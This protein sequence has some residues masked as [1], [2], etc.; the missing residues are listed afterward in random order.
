MNYEISTEHD[1]M[2]L[3]VI[4]AFLRDSYWF[5]GVRRD[6]VETAMRQSAVVGAFDTDGNQVGYMRAVTDYATFAYIC[7][8]FV[9]EAHR[10]RGLFR[11]MLETLFAD[12]RLQTLRRW[13]LATWDGQ[14]LYKKFGFEPVPAD[15]WLQIK[16]PPSVWK[17]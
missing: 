16:S 10:G 14:E 5:A 1:R 13:C 4:H 12:E 7:D 6:I 11:R 15:R 9:L 3:D 8:V 17:E 2:Q